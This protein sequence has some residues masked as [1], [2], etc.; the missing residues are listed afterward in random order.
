MTATVREGGEGG[1][2]D[3][4]M[5]EA[6]PYKKSLDGETRPTMYRDATP[7]AEKVTVPITPGTS[8]N[9]EYQDINIQNLKDS[10]KNH[11]MLRREN[12]KKTR[13]L[14]KMDSVYYRIRDLRDI[15]EEDTRSTENVT[16][17]EPQGDTSPPPPPRSQKNTQL[18]QPDGAQDP[19]RSPKKVAVH[20]PPSPT[21]YKLTPA[22]HP[23]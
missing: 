16:V 6:P 13:F 20:P 7:S 11:Q 12:E 8:Q 21:R 3:P 10:L 22:P 17:S 1:G 2:G 23:H 15:L 14:E 4:E 5:G 9:E 18:T 19:T